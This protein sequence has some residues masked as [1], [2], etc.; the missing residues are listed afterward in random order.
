MSSSFFP[1][2]RCSA[3][4]AALALL[5][6]T[7]SLA[8][9]ARAEWAAAW[10]APAQ[11]RAQSA[12]PLPGI[13][14]PPAQSLGGQTLRQRVHPGLTGER[15]RVRFSNA[16]GTVPLHIAGASIAHST[17][18]DAVS[19]GSLRDLRFDRGQPR[20]TIAPGAEAW[21]D[22]VAIRAE[23]GQALAVSFFLD[24]DTPAATVHHRPLQA[25]WIAPGNAVTAPR[26]PAA[27]PADWNHIVAGL[28]VEAP[29]A[30]R[31]VVA[32]GDS[33][34][35]GVGASSDMAS[36]P[37]P[38]RLGER[39]RQPGGAAVAVS[40]LNAGIGGNRL[41]APRAGPRG[42]DRFDRDVLSQSGVTHVIVLIGVNDIGFGTL[43]GGASA[44]PPQSSVS[45]EQLTAGLQ[46]LIAKARARGVKVLLGTLLPFKGSGYWSEDNEARRQ[47][48]NRWIRSR[49]DVDA[50]VDFDA[51]MRS[52]DD[53]L[54]LNPAYDSGDHLHPN[55][56]GNA[57][58]AAA[59]DMKELLE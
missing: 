1:L 13:A 26:L 42:L 22:A 56:A 47:A 55:D 35:E 33:I 53:P 54:M 48:V 51:T 6:A 57:A 21:S 18:G 29:A 52:A 44:L 4:C 23:P 8:T 34:T 27:R 39:L 12:P 24:R 15:V 40:V 14:H 9:P 50:V 5:C 46:Q 2:A 41:L 11:D 37:Y 7:S 36:R 20:I 30:T 32:F 59:V 25:S 19:P 16:F 43:P 3:R 28:D 38:E 58:M 10:A 45:A 49:Q 17:G 31:V